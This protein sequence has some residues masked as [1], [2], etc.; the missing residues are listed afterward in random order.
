MILLAIMFV[1]IFSMALLAV[2][3]TAENRLADTRFAAEQATACER[4]GGLPIFA[5]STKTKLLQCVK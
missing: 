3:Q 4:L 2:R 5:D 1:W